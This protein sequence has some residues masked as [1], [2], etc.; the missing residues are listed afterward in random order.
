MYLE[1]YDAICQIVNVNSCIN[2]AAVWKSVNLPLFDSPYM[3]CFFKV[4]LP[5]VDSPNVNY[6]TNNNY[7]F[8][9]EP[10]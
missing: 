3:L 9:R 7:L 1:N 2:K 5:F 10:K 8:T 4:N 6:G